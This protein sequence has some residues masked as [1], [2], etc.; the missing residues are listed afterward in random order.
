MAASTTDVARFQVFTLILGVSIA[1][2]FNK[3]FEYKGS[4][5]FVIAG[6]GIAYFVLAILFYH[7]KIAT[8]ESGQH[9]QSLRGRPG[10]ALLDYILN[11]LVVSAF[12]V[13]PYYLDNT[14]A[15][16]M[17]NIAMR[18]LD[19]ALVTFTMFKIT[20][21]NDNDLERKAQKSWAIFDLISGASYGV[22]LL[23]MTRYDVERLVIVLV[24]LIALADM[25][26]DYIVNRAFYAGESGSP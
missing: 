19:L 22:F 4:D 1:V 12:A 3:I 13:M 9:G 20:H 7:G 18:V 25:L 10:V 23:A 14:S 5:F 24:V 2:A 21:G 16:L 17:T 6:N 8:T 26:M 11:F 15:F